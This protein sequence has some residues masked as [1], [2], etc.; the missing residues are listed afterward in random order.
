MSNVKAPIF[1]DEWN[2]FDPYTSYFLI[3]GERSALY[4][5]IYYIYI[6]KFVR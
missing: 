4:Y 2:K 3:I 1:L 6:E 5:V